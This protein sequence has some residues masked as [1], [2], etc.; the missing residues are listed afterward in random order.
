MPNHDEEHFLHHNN[1][2]TCSVTA[3][4]KLKGKID[5]YFGLARVG[6]PLKAKVVAATVCAEKPCSTQD[7][8]K[9]SSYPHNKQKQVITNWST[10][11]NYH[12]LKAA[13]LDNLVSDEKA[14]VSSE[15]PI[16]T[17]SRHL[18]TF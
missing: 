1:F 6:R 7:K 18:Q 4:K 3:E 15:V 9:D 2:G 12:R 5:G 17:I 13:I 8:I 14:I 11:E 16:R 10:P